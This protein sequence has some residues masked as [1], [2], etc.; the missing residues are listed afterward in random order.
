MDRNIPGQPI[1]DPI[2]ALLMLIGLALLLRRFRQP[3]Y[4]FAV[5]CLLIM[6]IPSLLTNAGTP[7]YLRTTA[8]IPMLFILPALGFDRLWQA[9]ELRAPAM[10]RALPVLVVTLAFLSGAIHTYHSYFEVWPELP[11]YSQVFSTD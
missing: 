2:S 5:M 8:L 10:L 7:S 6:F 3:A 11:K 1:F 9:W 4:G